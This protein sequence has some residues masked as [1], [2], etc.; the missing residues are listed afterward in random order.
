MLT[1][2]LKCA[3]NDLEGASNIAKKH[4]TE[5]KKVEY[6]IQQENQ[7]KFIA[8]LIKDLE[9]TN[10]NEGQVMIA[11]SSG[12]YWRKWGI[13]YFYAL[14]IAHENEMC[15]NFKDPGL[16]LYGGELFK[17]LQNTMD[18]VF[19][20]LKPPVPSIKKYDA[21]GNLKVVQDMSNYYDYEGGCI[22][23]ECDVKMGDGTIR[24]I[25]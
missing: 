5:M 16:Q 22:Y 17:T 20:N 2:T 14:K 19:I 18:T 23:G 10:P 8:A 13:H 25:K 21:H 9:S 11:L 7:Q 15:T 3:G 12:E 1:K 24:K 6:K 4:L